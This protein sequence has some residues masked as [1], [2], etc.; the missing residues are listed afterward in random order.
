M[1]NV[2]VRDAAEAIGAEDVDIDKAF[3]G[4]RF[5]EKGVAEPDN[6]RL[7]TWFFNLQYD[8][9]EAVKSREARQVHSQDLISAASIHGFVDVTRVF[10]PTTNGHGGIS[11]AVVKQL[12]NNQ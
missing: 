3:E 1:L 11:D 10:H 8:H 5:C 9:T 2:V 12:R 7:D 4:H 6:E